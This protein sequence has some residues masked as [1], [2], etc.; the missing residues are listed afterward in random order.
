MN[1]HTHTLPDGTKDT[2]SSK[3]RTY[4]HVIIGRRNLARERRS[5]EDCRAMYAK[6]FAFYQRVANTPV[7]QPWDDNGRCLTTADEQA[8]YAAIVAQHG[9]AEAYA[10]AQVR[11]SLERIGSADAGPWGVLQWS[12]S[13]ANAAKSL[14]R[15]RE[16][17]VDVQVQPVTA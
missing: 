6:N 2:R 9:T 7:G 16:W 14:N 12:M 3:N 13:E 11:K 15:W 1:K 5:A 10:D 4:T 17:F 8:K